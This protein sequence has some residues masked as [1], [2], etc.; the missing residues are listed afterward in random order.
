MKRVVTAKY[1]PILNKCISNKL[2]SS[3]NTIEDQPSIQI[4]FYLKDIKKSNKQNSSININLLQ[5]AGKPLI[6]RIKKIIK[7]KVKK[8]ILLVLNLRF[9][10]IQM[11]Q[12]F[13][14]LY[15]LSIHHQVSIQSN[16]KLLKFKEHQQN[17]RYFNNSLKK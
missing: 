5:I 17:L 14:I 1:S 16:L 4:I 12:K 6:K 15:Q 2:M 10:V 8:I 13:L 9:K 3:S 11:S 7:S